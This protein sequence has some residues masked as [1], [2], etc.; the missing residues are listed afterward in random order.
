[1]TVWQAMHPMDLKRAA[2]DSAKATAVLS[3]KKLKTSKKT[4]NFFTINYSSFNMP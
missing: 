1:M 4:I 3:A 2:P